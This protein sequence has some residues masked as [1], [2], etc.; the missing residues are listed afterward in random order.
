MESHTLTISPQT[1][2]HFT[3]TKTSTP[4]NNPLLIFLHYWGGSSNTWH[5]QTSPTSPTSLT[6]THN[7]V[8]IDLRG[9]GQS[10]G[11]TTSPKDYSITPMADDILAILTHLQTTPSTTPLF[12]NGLILLGHSMGAKLALTVLSTLPPPLLILIKG[13]VLLAPAPPTPLLLPEEMATQ[14]K[15]AYTSEESIRWT[16]ENVLS[17]TKNLTK[18]DM[19]MI[20]RDSSS[21]NALARDGWIMYG[22]AEDITTLV[23]GVVGRLE[24]RKRKVRVWV[25]AGEEDVVEDK[26]KVER[27]VVGFL[28]QKEGLEVGFEVLGGMRHLVPLEEPG[29]VRRGVEWVVG[30]V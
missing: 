12:A 22:M 23:E 8:A 30:E 25:V 15:Q 13:L 5:K 4:N 9:W 27:E 6:T 14:Q 29:V 21:G 7:T 2:I 18:E 26:A 11:P 10:T 24:G 28:R 19:D 3:I 17:N 1:N 20:V 16:V